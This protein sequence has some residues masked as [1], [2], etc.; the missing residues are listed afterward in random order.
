MIRVCPERDAQCP[1]GMEC[2][3]A[4]DR[5]TCGPGFRTRPVGSGLGDRQ[6]SGANTSEGTPATD[7]LQ[8]S[9]SA[10]LSR[11]E[12]LREVLQGIL[13][14]ADDISEYTSLGGDYVVREHHLRVAREALGSPAPQRIEDE[15]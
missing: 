12:K 11:E 9:L 1:W 13:D 2:P 8:A 10:S 3:Y 4:V 5:Y 14:N 6:G 15:G 7:D